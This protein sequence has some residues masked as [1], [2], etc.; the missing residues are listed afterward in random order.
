MLKTGELGLWAFSACCFTGKL[1]IC[2]D[3]INCIYYLCWT[4]IFLDKFASELQCDVRG[5]TELR[6]RTL[7]ITLAEIK[8]SKGMKEA[9][10]QLVKRLTIVGYAANVIAENVNVSLHGEVYTRNMEWLKETPDISMASEE[11]HIPDAISQKYPI[12][13]QMMKI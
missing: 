4:S 2:C 7:F 5:S 12:T 6:E 8:S 9:V 11:L 13:I 10:K 1:L 3:I